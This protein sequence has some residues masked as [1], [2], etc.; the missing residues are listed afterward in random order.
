ML[1]A[2]RFKET[3]RFFLMKTNQRASKN[4]LNSGTNE[5]LLNAYER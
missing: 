5:K 4:L 1:S 2:K 3:H